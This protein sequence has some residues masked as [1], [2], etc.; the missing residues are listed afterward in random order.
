MNYHS[1]IF[2]NFDEHG[3][4]DNE[5]K[6]KKKLQPLKRLKHYHT[7]T[8]TK[9]SLIKAINYIHPIKYRINPLFR[10]LARKVGLCIIRGWAGTID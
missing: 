10:P 8:C 7:Y 2:F 9:A 5:N 4:F 3:Q 1:L 6:K